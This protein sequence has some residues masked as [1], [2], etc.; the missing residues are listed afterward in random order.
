M[1]ILEVEEADLGTNFNQFITIIFDTIEAYL[2]PCQTSKMRHFAKL[3]NVFQSLSIS[4]KRIIFDVR[5]ILNP[6]L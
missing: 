3:I 6:P 5:H 1:D 4:V 2:E